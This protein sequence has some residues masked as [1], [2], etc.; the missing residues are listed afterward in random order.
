MR[1]IPGRRTVRYTQA[2]NVSPPSPPARD[3]KRPH[4]FAQLL[5][6][7]VINCHGILKNEVRRGW[8]YG[9]AKL[10]ADA[11]C[12]AAAVALARLA[13]GYF[14]RTIKSLPARPRTLLGISRP[15]T[16]RCAMLGRQG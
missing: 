7:H 14:R 11:M 8:L 3:I 9:S 13:K 6:N 2:V 5:Q 16:F 10:V 4:R 12:G 15:A 1:A